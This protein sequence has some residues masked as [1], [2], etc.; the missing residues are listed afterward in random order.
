M[1]FFA[2]LQKWLFSGEL[3]DPYNE[4]FVSIHSSLTHTQHTHPSSISGG[5]I[6]GDGRFGLVIDND[7]ALGGKDSGLY[8]WETKYEFRSDMLP[9]FVGEEFGKK[10]SAPPVLMVCISF[11][12]D[13]LDWAQFEF[14]PV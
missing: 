10:V 7:E 3:Y 2:T 9:A 5:N 8:M 4:F 12:L 6:V 1:P 11:W 14:H 13:F